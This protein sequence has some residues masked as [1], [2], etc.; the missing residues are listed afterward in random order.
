MFRLFTC[1]FQL[2]LISSLPCGC[3]NITININFHEK[4]FITLSILLVVRPNLVTRCTLQELQTHVKSYFVLHVNILRLC[5]HVP[6]SWAAWDAQ[7]PVVC[8][9]TYTCISCIH[10]SVHMQYTY[11]YTILLSHSVQHSSTRNH[12]KHEV[13]DP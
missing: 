4:S 7:T 10:T 11:V 6:F 13:E 5:T 8:T 2:L 9:C 1:Q 3:N 12:T